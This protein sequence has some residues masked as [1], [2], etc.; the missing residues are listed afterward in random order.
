MSAAGRFVMVDYWQR[1]GYFEGVV[2]ARARDKGL[3]STVV[4]LGKIET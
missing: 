3:I 4:P 1:N 2:P